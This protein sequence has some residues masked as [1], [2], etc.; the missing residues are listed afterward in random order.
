MD[1]T[2]SAG[3]VWYAKG[4]RVTYSAS[5]QHKNAVVDGDVLFDKKGKHAS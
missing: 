2:L 1:L 5:A 3:L 4:M